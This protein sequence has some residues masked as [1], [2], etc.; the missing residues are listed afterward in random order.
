MSRVQLA[1]N[2][3]NLDEAVAFYSKLFA[4]APAKLRPG[5]ANFAV[6]D[7]PLKLVLIEDAGRGAGTINHLGVEVATTEEGAAAGPAS[8]RAALALALS[9]LL[10]LL[11]P[12]L[13][14]VTEEVWSWWHDGSIHRAPWPQLAELTGEAGAG[15]AAGAGD[16]AVLDRAAEGLGAI[17]RTKTEA[18]R[19]MRWPVA[20]VNVTGDPDQLAAVRAAAA[21]LADA[22]GLAGGV[23]TLTTG[24]GAW[25]VQVVLGE[26]SAPGS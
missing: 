9:V 5:Y 24:A 3:A 4:T 22:G 10:R 25:A 7:P 26:Q 14:F 23:E 12:F 8:A 6:A 20:T 13:V 21:D 15:L 17:R 2:V 19:S 1:L 16:T 18:K 11:A